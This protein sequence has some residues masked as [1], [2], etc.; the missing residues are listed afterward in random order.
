PDVVCNLDFAARAGEFVCILGGNGTGKTTT[1]K[2]LAGLKKPY[3]GEVTTNGKVCILQQ[4]PRTLF[5]KK[6]VFADLEDALFESQLSKAQALE[7]ITRTLSLCRLNGLEERHPYDLSGGE[8]QRAALAKLLLTDPEILLLDE[9]TKGLDAEF[10]NE[11]AD[12]LREL[13]DVGVCIVMVSHDVEFCVEYADRC[14]L[15]FDGA[16]A[17]E[18]EPCRFFSGNNFYTTAANRISRGIIPGAV[19]VGDVV[20]ALDAKITETKKSIP[21]VP[22]RVVDIKPEK[23]K[24]RMP[25][26]RKIGAAVC[27][28]IAAAVYF[29]AMKTE[30]FGEM[31]GQDGVTQLGAKQLC[32]YGIMIL[33]LIFAA[34]FLERKKSPQTASQ[35]PDKKSR[36][37]SKRTIAAIVLILLLIPATLY[38]GLVFLD[39]KQYYIT[40]LAVLV[41]CML[42]FFMVFEGRKPKA[43]EL[44]IIS[45]LCALAIAGRAAFFMFPQFKP[46]L[47]IVIIAG[48]A[49]GGETGFL[50][51]AVTMLVSNIMFSQGPWTPW[52]MFAAGIIGFLAGVLC[53]IGLLRQTR[54]SLCI[55]GAVCALVIYGGIMNSVSALIWSSES[56]NLNMILGY[57]LTGLPMDCIHAAATAVFLW[58]LTEPMLEKLERVKIKYGLVE[59]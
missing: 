31:L 51:G 12:I 37:L 8:M 54:V 47:A 2:L 27:G 30:S 36:R 46:V 1:L 29:Y 10:K 59:K 57:Y 39:N 34:V 18:D 19:T 15:F 56:L 55:F 48:A 50:V 6:T 24:Q 41:E 11:F 21:V 28:M 14:A 4:D 13:L 49:F 16:I 7:K 35:M 44:V 23:S 32:L 43:R 17:A 53:K 58:F 25:L 20:S 9:P 26:W 3:R 33:S 45:V 40:A 52:Q 5:V 22:A 38:M 42:P